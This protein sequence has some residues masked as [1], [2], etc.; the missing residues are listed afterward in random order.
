MSDSMTH[1]ARWSDIRNL[2]TESY[3]GFAIIVAISYF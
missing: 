2:N 1:A 3:M